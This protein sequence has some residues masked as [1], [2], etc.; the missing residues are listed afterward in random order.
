MRFIQRTAVN[1]QMLNDYLSARLPLWTECRTFMGSPPT[2]LCQILSYDSLSGL[3]RWMGT[4]SRHHLLPRP[5]TA[6]V[7]CDQLR[8]FV[9]KEFD[10]SIGLVNFVHDKSIHVHFKHV[11]TSFWL[12][13]IFGSN[14]YILTGK[15]NH[16]MELF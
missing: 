2:I 6:Q 16:D 7:V 3:A 14:K 8:C 13:F 10:L 15:Q 1:S 11:R 5:V 9:S 12:Y 4:R